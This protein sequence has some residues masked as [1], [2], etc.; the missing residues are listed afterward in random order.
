MASPW[1]WRGEASPLSPR[2]LALRL[3]PSFLGLPAMWRAG[4]LLRPQV[5]VGLGVLLGVGVEQEK[6]RILGLEGTFKKH[7]FPFTL[8]HWFSRWGPQTSSTCITWHWLEMQT[9]LVNQEL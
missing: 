3:E 8:A 1:R 4:L 5:L 7:H 9:D 6:H 2:L